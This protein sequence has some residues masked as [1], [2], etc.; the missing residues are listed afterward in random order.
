[1]K[2]TLGTIQNIMKIGR[3]I[4]IIVLVCAII[5]MVG[6]LIGGICVYAMGEEI[7]SEKVEMED[8]TEIT[9]GELV[10]DEFIPGLEAVYVIM[11]GAFIACLVE[12]II[13][14]RAQK[15]FKFEIKEGTPF[16]FEGAKK[17]KNFG[18]VAIVL[19]LVGSII[20][21]GVIIALSMANP[22]ALMGEIS[23]TASIGTGVMAIL[24][25]LVFKHGAE[26]NEVQKK[27]NL[28]KE[29]LQKKQKQLEERRNYYY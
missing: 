3:V 24:I 9:I 25:A 19:P 22:E 11:I 4:S 28:E 13:S 26:L 20:T 21:E 15:Y 1:M 12:V 6:S 10:F 7:I 8:G 5:G 23:F 14:D 2:K 16:T 27:A 29:A 17:L 18:I